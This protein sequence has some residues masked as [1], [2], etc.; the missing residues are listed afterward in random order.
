MGQ[1]ER[2]HVTKLVPEHGLPIDGMTHVRCRA[3]RGNNAAETN[4]EVTWIPRH[5]KSAH[6]EIFLLIKDFNDGWPRQLETIFGAEVR[7]C[8]AEEVQS[9]VPVNGRFPRIH[10]DHEILIGDGGES[11]HGIVQGGQIKKSHIVAI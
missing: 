6:S 8:S 4:A 7:L 2:D 9:L 1:L 5:P 10:A 3:V 11:L